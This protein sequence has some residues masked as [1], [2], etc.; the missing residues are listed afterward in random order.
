MQRPALLLGLLASPALGFDLQ[1]H[2]VARGLA[3]E[4]TLA[5]FTRALAIGVTTLELDLAMTRDGVLVVSHDRRLNP[6]HTRGPDGQFLAAEGPPI[7]SL[8]RIGTRT[9]S[10]GSTPRRNPGH[11]GSWAL[12]E[13]VKG[14]GA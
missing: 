8:D 12:V 2:R 7:R 9:G 11:R 14:R 5:A 1:G 3:P 6:D 13:T 4:N 10:A